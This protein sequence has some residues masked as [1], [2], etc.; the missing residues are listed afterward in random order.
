[1][2][3]HKRLEFLYDFVSGPCYLASTQVGEIASAV[4]AELVLI[5]VLAGGI[6]KATNNPGP[7]AVPAKA[8]WIAGDMLLWAGFYGVEFKPTPYFPIRTL[9]LLRGALVA[10]ERGE[11]DRYNRAIFEAI[12]VHQRNLNEPEEV[13]RVLI[14]SG[15]DPE[16]YFAE[17]ERTQIKEQ[18]RRNT[19]DAVT[20]GAFGVPT[21]FV[22]GEMFFGQDRLDFLRSALERAVPAREEATD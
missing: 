3:S 10:A 19:D 20:R 17:I 9:P 22:E 12:W 18:L 1:M 13:R 15:F 21:F 14:S 7:L 4:G 16:I 2:T 11:V 8:K 5:P 6:L